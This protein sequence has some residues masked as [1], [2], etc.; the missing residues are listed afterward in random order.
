MQPIT[1]EKSE[2]KM[3]VGI[4]CFL[5][6]SY[7]RSR[8]QIQDVYLNQWLGGSLYIIK[9][10]LSISFYLCHF[11]SLATLLPLPRTSGV[12]PV[13]LTYGGLY[14]HVVTFQ[15]LVKRLRL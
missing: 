3:T 5:Y 14:L 12:H 13:I 2:K 11:F 4:F 10:M 8:T 1:C 9:T 15:R 6:L 7:V